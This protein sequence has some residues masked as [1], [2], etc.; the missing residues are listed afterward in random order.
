[1]PERDSPAGHS[2][3]LL[4][5]LLWA[6]VI[7]APVAG[8]VVLLGGTGNSVRF[9]I[10][11]TAVSVVLVG[12]SVLIRSDPVLLR[13][14]VEDRV[15]EEVDRLRRGL[16]TELAGHASA[17]PDPNRPPLT[18]HRAPGRP[19]AID[20]DQ[21]PGHDG[22]HTMGFG[23]N[24][25]GRQGNFVEQPGFETPPAPQNVPAPQGF[26]GPHDFAGPQ[27]FDEPTTYGPGPQ[28]FDS[29]FDEQP[30]G[31]FDDYAQPDDGPQHAPEPPL[32]PRP[33]GGRAVVSGSARPM[34]P[35]APAGRAS[36][37]VPI[38]SASAAVPAASAAVPAAAVVPP[39]GAASVPPAAAGTARVAAAA[40]V[41]PAGAG[42]VYGSGGHPVTR[43]A[44]AYGHPEA[45]NGDFGYAPHDNGYD[46]GPDDGN[47]YGPKY[48]T[49][50][51]PDDGNRY[52]P[53]SGTG[54]EPGTGGFRPTPDDPAQY[55]ARRHRP[56][57]NDTNVG[58]L[59]D[60]ANMPGYRD[61]A[62]GNW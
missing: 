24:G 39:R 33:A 43:P 41:P 62:P 31:F 42:A 8:A 54:F 58:S 3:R 60:F 17:A 14:D 1:M 51:G 28:G 36:A 6:G 4:R 44:P 35:G 49:G 25:R 52:G 57:A 5:G 53:K 40:V 16:I 19:L 10:L 23:P 27:G 22:E 38:S 29:G 30:S 55:Q 11:L 32:P 48:G 37:A 26:A 45:V 21:Q 56:S 12:A 2:A 46:Y 61:E 9:G 13:I 50:Y 34:S 15:A 47:G 59:A 7:L 20:R 18:E